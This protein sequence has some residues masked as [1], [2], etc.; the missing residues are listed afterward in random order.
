M[1]AAV[2]SAAPARTARRDTGGIVSFTALARRVS[3]W[4]FV[5]KV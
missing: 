1:R 4:I 5:A 3:G 2:V